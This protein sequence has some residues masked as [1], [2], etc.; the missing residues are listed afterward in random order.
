MGRSSLK[1]SDP[2]R[3]PHDGPIH[4]AVTTTTTTGAAFAAQ[5]LEFPS[6][7]AVTSAVSQDITNVGTLLSSVALQEAL[8]LLSRCTGEHEETE[9][10]NLG[11]VVALLREKQ[12]RGQLHAL[13]AFR[14][15]MIQQ[16]QRRKEQQ[17]GVAEP[18]VDDK[19]AIEALALY[20]IL[21][22]ASLSYQ[23]PQ[24][25]RRTLQSS[26]NAFDECSLSSSNEDHQLAL[27]NVRD[28]VIE[29]ILVETPGCW[30]DPLLSLQEALT[31]LP[32]QERL[33]QSTDTRTA[34]LSMLVRVAQSLSPLLKAP[35]ATNSASAGTNVDAWDG[36]VRQAVQQA[37]AVT[38]LIKIILQPQPNVDAGSSLDGTEARLVASLAEFCW[39]LLSECQLLPADS[40]ATVG[41]AYGR[42][43]QWD[44]SVSNNAT[45]T[46]LNV[47][48]T[49][50]RAVDCLEDLQA[51]AL[52]QG[53]A[54]TIS[55]GVLMIAQD[56]VVGEA[57]SSP[58]DA[59]TRA[60]YEQSSKAVDPEV[61]V[62]V[63][64][65]LRSLV[66]RCTLL[67]D[68]PVVLED[69]SQVRARIHRFAEETLEVVLQ[70]WENPPTRKL[71]SSIPGLFEN[72][73][74][75]M[76]KFDTEEEDDASSSSRFSKLVTRILAQ[77]PNRKGRYLALDSLL[78]IT[79]AKCLIEAD[80]SKRL[81]KDLLAGIGDS[82]HNTVAIADLWA[83]LLQL[84]LQEMKLE[85]GIEIVPEKTPSRKQR[86]R[87]AK[88]QAAAGE[89]ST[90]SCEILLPEWRDSWVP[91]LVESLLSV[92][93]SR[94]KQVAAFCLPRIEQVVGGYAAKNECAQVF[95]ALLREIRRLSYDEK[96]RVELPSLSR[97]TFLDRVMWAECEVCRLAAAHG[98]L[99]STLSSTTKDL[100]ESV[101]SALSVDRLH[102][103]LTHSSAKI[104]VA[105]FQAME[106]VA[107]ANDNF[108]SNSFRSIEIQLRLWKFAL[109]FAGKTEGK[110]YMSLLLQ[111]LSS[112]LDRLSQAESLTA[113]ST[114]E[115]GRP[116]PPLP[117]L[118]SFVVDFLLND[119]VVQKS[120]YPG[121]VMDKESFTLSLFECIATFVAREHPLALDSKLLA[122]TGAIFERRRNPLEEETLVEIRKAVFQREIFASLYSMLHSTWDSSRVGSFRLLS[123]L[124]PL[125][126]TYGISLPTEYDDVDARSKMESRG[127]FLA[128]SPRQRE[129][130]TGARILA[131]LY[132]SLSSVPERIVA[133]A[134]LVNLLEQR[135]S[136]MKENLIAVLADH[137]DDIAGGQLPLAH[138]IIL[139]LR[140]IVE[141]STSL[142]ATSET[143]LLFQRTTKVFCR[144]IQ[145]SLAVVADLREGEVMDGMDEDIGFGSTS[146]TVPEVK[147]ANVSP[148]AIGA[149]G[150]FSALR[151]TTEEERARRIASQRIIIGSW[152][153]TKETCNA[154]A[155]VLT[156]RGFD[157]PVELVNDTGML[158]I[159]TLTSLKHTGTA[160]AANRALQAIAKMCL[161]A[162][163]A[164]QDVEQLPSK[165]VSRLHGEIL[166]TDKVRNSTLRRS[167]GHALGFLS[168]M[169]SEVSSRVAPRPLCRRILTDILRLSLPS[170]QSLESFIERVGLMKESC[171]FPMFSFLSGADLRLVPADQYETRSRIHALNILRLIVLDAP[172]SQEVFPVI[173]DAIAAAIIGYTDSS[174]AIRNS[175]TM[176]FAAAMLRRIDADKN[177]TNTD[178][179]SSNAITVT[180]FFRTYP[181]LPSFLLAV[182]KASASGEFGGQQA[183]SLPPIFP[184][185]LLLSRF[186]PVTSSGQDAVSQTEPFIPIILDCLGHPH[187]FIRKGAARALANLS[188]AGKQSPSSI[189]ALLRYC[190]TCIND[191]MELQ[192]KGQHW[193]R[194][195]GALVVIQEFVV[196]T[197]DAREVLRELKL[198]ADLL[199]MVS[200]DLGRARVPPSCMMVAL[201]ILAELETSEEPSLQRE[202]AS[203][204]IV[205]W[206]ERDNRAAS[207]IG[208]AEL[209]SIA[210]KLASRSVCSR[211]WSPSAKAGSFEELLVNLSALLGCDLIDVRL[212]ATKAF[213]KSIYAGV[214]R[215]VES[216]VDGSGAPRD[217]LVSL[218]SMLAK[219]LERE[220]KR[221][222]VSEDIVGTHPPTLRRLSRCLLE[223]IVA[224]ERLAGR[225]VENRMYQV[226]WH[227]GLAIATR[228]SSLQGDVPIG[229][230]PPVIGNACELMAFDLE[231]ADAAQEID[232][233]GT[234]TK[235]VELLSEPSSAWRLR[236]SA[237]VA[238]DTS[239]ILSSTSKTPDVDR[240]NHQVPM[241]LTGFGMLQDADADARHT[242]S[243][244]F[245][246]RLDGVSDNSVP[247]RI[248]MQAYKSSCTAL[249]S[250]EFT[251]RLLSGVLDSCAGIEDKVQSLLAELSQSEG[252]ESSSSELLNVG[253]DRSIF[254]Q[255]EPNAYQERS[256]TNQL[257]ILAILEMHRHHA[258][259]RSSDRLLQLC[260]RALAVLQHRLP[261]EM[262]RELD[263]LHDITRYNAIFPDLHCLFLGCICAL[264][265][266]GHDTYNVQATANT[267]ASSA[268]AT[269]HPGIQEA[270][271]IL[272]VVGPNDQTTLAAVRKCCFLIPSEQWN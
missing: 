95:D 265:L 154:L 109:P 99:D 161:S 166:E 260:Q 185:F 15:T 250:N 254:E 35:P 132:L 67:Y 90:P 88:E 207:A 224:F 128:S 214:D 165:W 8:D 79:G 72:L 77:P 233:I 252:A 7:E 146:R 81:L 63:I 170:Q 157:P 47:Q 237:A 167:T 135:I 234:F 215:L 32:T 227:L 112:F 61:R 43:M 179:T 191:T 180:E 137:S 245:S 220:I 263:M 272:A 261:S 34:A 39:L 1:Q 121:T 110:E 241:T 229:L 268:P 131:L 256:L 205:E 45:K 192:Q 124:F 25:F 216:E 251:E 223:S 87:M 111:G 247:E 195:H 198:E 130:D 113:I 230:A 143:G 249:A 115:E 118:Y 206:L 186:Q 66:G 235:L 190:K 82:G 153:L 127:I 40:M 145:V 24:P 100:R 270:L 159:S 23:T 172:L 97:E 29:S 175:A 171:V 169:R 31:Y 248:L 75:L 59:L 106:F 259:N 114:E 98:L 104:R 209:A 253:T 38:T 162:E 91:S 208:A 184:I 65:G 202:Q 142:P 68:S 258:S 246:T 28:S 27:Q 231:T 58:L 197:T 13:Q 152:L 44:A 269:M 74:R 189:V 147:L 213:K 30:K 228:D 148:G 84:L 204:Q 42:T 76:Q 243:R 117:I 126:M 238:L 221:E 69:A 210:A 120:A 55:D 96:Q 232:K 182:M 244:A 78:P 212:A 108:Q 211:I 48:E 193:N 156:K 264:F 217:R 123:S 176:V 22:E 14:S 174:W 133:L 257:S 199:R 136:L 267:I 177:A 52:A 164:S 219:S 107:D 49:L 196:S 105:A 187:L 57:S 2:I 51:T 4:L 85:R 255:E 188:S 80:G 155:V 149:N 93:P 73:V 218:I 26:L 163:K 239:K 226:A 101:A 119:I 266:G 168:I 178:V 236:H 181:M 17:D 64:K 70:A 53:L 21:L 129:A 60:F 102:V 46:A 144:A 5:Q 18:G 139:S 222:C 6:K 225:H 92:E 33:L 158:L 173:G 19:G 201:D 62:A 151:R 242:T 36:Q 103:A 122:K 150:T 20:R 141:Q 160:F 16:E 94:R 194:L 86:L 203:L 10:L 134:K 183:M 271:S 12:V 89:T 116:D 125:A 50:Q 140:L 262:G 71:G 56:D 11:L 37:V 3:I 54:A 240:P 9:S 41:I 138:G 200:V 83:K